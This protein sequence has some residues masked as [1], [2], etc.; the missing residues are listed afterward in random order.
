MNV[1]QAGAGA[2]PGGAAAAAPG[3]APAGSYQQPYGAY[4]PP[5]GAFHSFIFNF[6]HNHHYYLRNFFMLYLLIFHLCAGYYGGQPQAP[7]PGGVPQGG[8]GFPAYGYG[9]QQGSA[10]TSSQDN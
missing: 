5:T 3:Q 8:Y 10:P 1:G 6:D 7:V 9:G 2:P 4:Q